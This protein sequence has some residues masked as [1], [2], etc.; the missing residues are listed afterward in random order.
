MVENFA[1]LALEIAWCYLIVSELPG[2]VARLARRAE[3]FKSSYVDH[4][5][6]VTALKGSKGIEMQLLAVDEMDLA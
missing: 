1:M 6:R 4:M 5:V 3:K 2:A